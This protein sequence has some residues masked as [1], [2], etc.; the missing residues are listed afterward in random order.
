MMNSAGSMPRLLNTELYVAAVFSLKISTPA[1]R[2]PR[3]E[4]ASLLSW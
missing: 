1:N 4:R 3:P 2:S